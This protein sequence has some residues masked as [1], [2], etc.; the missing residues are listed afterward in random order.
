MDVN[1]ARLRCLLN[2]T[3]EAFKQLLNQPES[4]ELNNAYES[5]KSEL[6][7]YVNQLKVQVSDRYTR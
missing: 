3:D 5:A 1:N 7:Q 6:D 2:R 4:N